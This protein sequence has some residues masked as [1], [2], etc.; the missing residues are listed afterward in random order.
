MNLR[1]RTVGAVA[2]LVIGC[3]APGLKPAG[4]APGEVDTGYGTQPKDKTTGAVTSVSDKETARTSS[5][6]LRLEDLLR[7]K[8]SGVQIVTLPDG[9]QALR[10]RG[11]ANIQS[12]QMEPLIVVDGIQLGPNGLETALAGLTPDDIKQVDVLK[13]VASTSIY[14]Q[15]GASGVIVI[16]TKRR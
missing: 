10:I 3:G 16:S 5:S 12:A 13:D 11:T 1:S 8:A 4:P 14:G 2:L 15:R 7:G 6:P 9:R